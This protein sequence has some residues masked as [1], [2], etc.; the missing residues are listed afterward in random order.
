MKTLQG[1]IPA[2]GDI[3][4]WYARKKYKGVLHLLRAYFQ[5]PA[6]RNLRDL[7]AIS[8]PHGSFRFTERRLMGQR[9]IPVYFNNVIRMMLKGIDG[10]RPHFDDI[11]I[12]ADT[13]EKFIEVI[14]KASSRIKEYD[15]VIA[16]SKVKLG[17][18]KMIVLEFDVGL[19][20]F[21]PRHRLKQKLLNAEMPTSKKEVQQWLGLLAQFAKHVDPRAWTE[22]QSVW[23]P[24]LGDKV[25]IDQVPKE[26]KTKAF[27]LLK[28]QIG[29]I[30]KLYFFCNS[31]NSLN[32][33]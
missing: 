23:S 1:N 22:I 24:I 5:C 16:R 19:N 31:L 21:S 18:S 10:A 12:G 17:F 9:G 8:T 29:D 14:D 13:P 7:F 4:R 30:I 25:R 27:N 2:I 26:K 11:L 6:S 15:G 20:Y 3:V 33:L 28:E 32:V